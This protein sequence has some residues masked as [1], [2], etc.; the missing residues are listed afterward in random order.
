[1]QEVRLARSGVDTTEPG[2]EASA[3]LRAA[4]DVVLFG[5]ASHKDLGRIPSFLPKLAP[6]GAVW[7]V[8]RKGGTPPTEND[9]LAAGR[10]AG[11]KD[12][13][14]A[15]FSPTHTALKFVRPLSAR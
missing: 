12:V 3:Q 11:L 10:A 9:V 8:Y 13:K 6:A 7:V 4:T 5:A 2:T 14:V 1:M 15:R